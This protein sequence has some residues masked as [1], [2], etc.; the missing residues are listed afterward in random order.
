M[1][2]LPNASSSGKW[3]QEGIKHPKVDEFMIGTAQQLTSDLRARGYGR[4]RE[5][6]DYLE[7]TNNTARSL[8]D[9]P[10]DIPG[11]DYVADLCNTSLSACGPNTIRGAIGSG[12]T[13]VIANLDGAFTKYYEATMES[14][15]R[16]SSPLYVQGSYTWSHYYGNF[17]Q[18]NSSFSNANDAAIFI[19]SSN[20][21]DGAGRQLWNN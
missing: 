11:G 19:G 4:Y 18:D 2:V 6:S 9:A 21:A 10:D 17:D 12:S 20:I 5:G 14:S 7:D 15:W 3:W 16:G 1:G 13:Y 8:A